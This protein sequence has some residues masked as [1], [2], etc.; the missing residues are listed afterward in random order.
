MII[1]FV[2]SQLY[3]GIVLTAVVIVTGIFSYYQEAKSSAIMD[4]FKNLVP[5]V[6]YVFM[7]FPFF[8][9]NNN[10]LHNTAFDLSHHKMKGMI[11]MMQLSTFSTIHYHLKLSCIKKIRFFS[12]N[13]FFFLPIILL[14]CNS[15]LILPTGKKFSYN[16][17]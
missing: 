16:C 1:L 15:L 3:L 7:F 8:F 5:Q 10:K 12:E 11:Q 6:N 13:L 17:N 14:N 4:S 9:L 2:C